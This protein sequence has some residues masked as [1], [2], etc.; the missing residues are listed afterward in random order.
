MLL[1]APRRANDGT[2]ADALRPLIGAIDV[3][4]MRE[5]DLRALDGNASPDAA[6]RWLAEE[7]ARRKMPR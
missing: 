2:L 7:I 1:L 3:T 6:A 4:L 5:A